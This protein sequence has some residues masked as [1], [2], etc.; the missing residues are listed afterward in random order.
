MGTGTGTIVYRY[1]GSGGLE[2]PPWIFTGT[3]DR[4]ALKCL[5]DV[6]TIQGC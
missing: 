4:E 1:E 2:L 6:D 3:I 5:E